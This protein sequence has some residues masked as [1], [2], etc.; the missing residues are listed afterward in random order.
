MKT[1]LLSAAALATIVSAPAM[2]APVNHSGGDGVATYYIS[3]S[4]SDYC[5]L[6]QATAAGTSGGHNV[7]VDTTSA[8]TSGY[9]GT[10]SD[11][12]I[13]ITQ[14]Q[15]TNDHAASWRAVLNLRHSVCN[16]AYTVTANSENGGLQY[17]GTQNGGDDFFKKTS[18]TVEADFGGKSGNPKTAA[19]LKNGGTL[20]NSNRA[21][22]GDFKLTF[23][24][25]A[26]NSRYLLSGDYTD[27]VVVTMSPN[28]GTTA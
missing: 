25:A 6:G 28:T 4:A 2:A 3:G 16:T 20:L 8:N 27:R 7:T 17:Q 5:V 14:F 23:D 11:A 12:L 9:N 10:T 22:S 26:D 19:S 13:A 21:S 18:Y 24:G 15:N 1:V